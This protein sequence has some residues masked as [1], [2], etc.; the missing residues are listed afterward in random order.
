MAFFIIV[1]QKHLENPLLFSSEADWFLLGMKYCFYYNIVLHNEN[2]E[3]EI[4][5]PS[6]KLTNGEN[7]LSD[8]LFK[9]QVNIFREHLKKVLHI[10]KVGNG[11]F[12]CFLKKKPALAES[13]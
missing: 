1:L 6:V 9:S 12:C 3:K 4:I 8:V 5:E 10:M 11:I 2:T 13:W 7:S